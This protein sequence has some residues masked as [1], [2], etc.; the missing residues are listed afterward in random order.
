MNN[1]GSLLVFDN[2]TRLL[3]NT[4]KNSDGNLRLISWY[5]NLQSYKLFYKSKRKSVNKEL[6]N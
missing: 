5:T 2:D 6:S 3:L 1:T 4:V